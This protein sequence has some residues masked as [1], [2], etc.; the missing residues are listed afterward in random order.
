MAKVEAEHRTKLEQLNSIQV[1]ASPSSTLLVQDEGKKSL[2]LNSQALPPGQLV[3]APSAQVVFSATTCSRTTCTTSNL[4]AG[5]EQHGL[6]VH[7]PRPLLLPLPPCHLGLLSSAIEYP[8]L[9]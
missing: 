6:Y 3:A 7:Q 1:Q 4:S 5:G 2:S 9:P 8:G